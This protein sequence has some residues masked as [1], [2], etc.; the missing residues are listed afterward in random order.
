[1][2]STPTFQRL[3]T[4]LRGSVIRTASVVPEPDPEPI[5]AQPSRLTPSVK[6]ASPLHLKRPS[7]IQLATPVNSATPTGSDTT[8][9]ASHHLVS[10]SVPEPTPPHHLVTVRM[11]PDDDGRFGFN[12]KGW[13]Q[14]SLFYKCMHL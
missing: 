6:Q 13:C 7:P 2:R 1:M 10:I 8:Q 4:I 9:I 5:H 14:I 11:T 12:V 3:S